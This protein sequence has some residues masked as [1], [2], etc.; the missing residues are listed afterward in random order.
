VRVLDG[1]RPLRVTG[2]RPGLYRVLWTP[3]GTGRHVLRATVVD[4]DGR[5]A[6]AERSLRAGCK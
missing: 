5:R 2:T 6:T 4:V 3:H 1:T